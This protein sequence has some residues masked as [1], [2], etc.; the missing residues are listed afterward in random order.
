VRTGRLRASITHQLFKERDLPTVRIGTNVKYGVYVHEGTGVWG[1][2]HRP[3]KPVHSKFLR[4]R[5]NA[6]KFVYTRQ[7]QGQ[8]PKPYLQQALLAAIG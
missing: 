5:G 1:P 6:G 7:V 2:K 4:F 8:R 3:I